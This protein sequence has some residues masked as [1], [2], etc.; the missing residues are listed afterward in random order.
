MSRFEAFLSAAALVAWS[1]LLL[2]AGGDPAEV[3]FSPRGGCTDLIVREVGTAKK[4]VRVLAYSFTSIPIGDC[5]I[6]A[7]RRGVSV[8]VV[9]DGGE[10]DQAHD[11]GARLRTAGI[12]VAYDSRHSIMH[13]KVI[14]LDDAAVMT[15]SFNFT[16]VAE[17]GNA[18]NLLL[19]RDAD[20]ARRYAA[21][22]ELHRG[23]AMP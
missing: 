19:L 14:V 22:F 16:A 18:E 4:T 13:D 3:R 8:S 1:L 9:I 6:A 7:K 21:E 2:A 11:Q 15:G 10:R 5:L 23:H 20:L 17:H 12:T